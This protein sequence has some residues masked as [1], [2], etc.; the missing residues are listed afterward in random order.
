MILTLQGLLAVGIFMGE[1]N[2]SGLNKGYVG[3]IHGGGAYSLGIQAA[4][5]VSIIAWSAATT[6]IVCTVS[7]NDTTSS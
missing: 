3:L 4:A 6:L 5:A 2:L 7:T 1:E